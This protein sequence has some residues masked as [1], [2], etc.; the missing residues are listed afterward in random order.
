[1][2]FVGYYIYIVLA[3]SGAFGRFHSKQQLIDKYHKRQ[4]QAFESKRYFNSVAEVQPE[5]SFNCCYGTTVIKGNS[6]KSKFN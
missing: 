1:M 6:F 2:P 3:F 5:E 4:V